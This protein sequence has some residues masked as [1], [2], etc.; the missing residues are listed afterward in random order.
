MI[1]PSTGES[2]KSSLASNEARRAVESGPTVDIWITVVPSPQARRNAVAAL[3]HVG[4][5]LRVRD[6]RDHRLDPPGDVGGALR[7]ECAGD[8]ERLGHRTVAVPDDE[9]VAGAGEPPRDPAAHRSQA[10]DP[11]CRHG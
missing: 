2:S 10:D 3:G 8:C 9:V 1:E 7:D 5:R 4:E 6:H 11:D